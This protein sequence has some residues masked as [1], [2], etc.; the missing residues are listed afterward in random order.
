MP[1]G[2]YVVLACV[3]K[4]YYRLVTYDETKFRL[5]FACIIVEKATTLCVIV[6]SPVCVIFTKTC[7]RHAVL[8]RVLE[9]TVV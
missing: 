5:D 9:F 8:L 1:Q 7:E 4:W 2:V 3:N 6:C